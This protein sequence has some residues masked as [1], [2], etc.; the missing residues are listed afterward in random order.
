MSSRS[1]AITALV[2]LGFVA[3]LLWTT[4]AGQRAQCEV[5]VE[6]GG[7]RNCATA[8]H[9]SPDEAARS[10][11]TTACGPLARGMNEIIACQDRPPVSRVCRTL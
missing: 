1:K 5:C 11:Q 7:G 4:L 6:F 3:F 10:A 8:S 2:V 9:S